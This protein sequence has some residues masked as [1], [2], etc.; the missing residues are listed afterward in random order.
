MHLC[1]TG[2]KSTQAAEKPPIA[3]S[4]PLRRPSHHKSSDSDGQ[5]PSGK[6]RYGHEPSNS[7]PGPSL[8]PLPHIICT[9]ATPDRRTTLSTSSPHSPPRKSYDARKIS[10]DS[11]HRSLK[12]KEKEASSRQHPDKADI[13]GF[14]TIATAVQRGES[15]FSNLTE[16]NKHLERIGKERESSFGPGLAGVGTLQRDVSL[17]RGK[18]REEQLR[19]RDAERRKLFRQQKQKNDQA[20]PHDTSTV[21]TDQTGG[22]ASTVGTAQSSS[23]GRAAGK[24]SALSGKTASGSGLPKTLIH[25]PA[26][27]F[28]P[29]VPS[30]SPRG[31]NG[32]GILQDTSLTSTDRPSD[33]K[34]AQKTESR[35]ERPH[36]LLSAPATIGHRSALK[37][38]S[39]D[40]GLGFA[41]APSSVR[42]EA[43]LPSLNIGRSFSQS[44]S[45][46]SANERST[47]SNSTG[48]AKREAIYE[49]EDGTEPVSNL[50][51]EIGAIFKNTLDHEGFVNFR[52][53]EYKL[54]RWSSNADCALDVHQFDAHEIPFDGPTGITTRVEQLLGKTSTLRSYEKKQLMDQLVRIILRNA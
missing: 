31:A 38:R 33:G 1:V 3:V 20:S 17:K 46:K 28:E 34:K 12:G 9:P 14:H 15:G 22:S 49:N 47:P 41:W 26:F 7:L 35:E 45:V 36:I 23:W 8:P 24:R 5:R 42:E 2:S 39:L 32:T 10:L 52:K 6:S 4:G 37:G 16:W 44:S 13:G 11:A 54:L 48:H 25:H 19:V 51:K 21:E 43:L 30:S 27:D 40:L 18:E 53:C 29:P 50:G